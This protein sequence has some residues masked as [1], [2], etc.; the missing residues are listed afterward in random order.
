MST[1]Q[2]DDCTNDKYCKGYCQKH[3][4]RLYRH[5]SPE[6]VFSTALHKHT[7]E[8]RI[9]SRTT[10]TDSCW[11]WQGPYTSNG[12][13]QISDSRSGEH[14]TRLVHRVSYELYVAPIPQGLQI[15][16]LCRTKECLNPDHLAL[17]TNDENNR[18]KTLT[19]EEHMKLGGI[20]DAS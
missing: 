6:A 5:G 16:H 3:Y 19:A 17:V 10:K 13:G 15:D 18:R 2:L 9:L 14:K 20:K 7:I 11:L 4:M 1:C 8:E 12:Y